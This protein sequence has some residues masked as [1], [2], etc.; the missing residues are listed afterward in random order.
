MLENDFAECSRVTQRLDVPQNPTLSEGLYLHASCLSGVDRLDE[1]RAYFERSLAI[2]SSGYLMEYADTLAAQREYSAARQVL[3][4]NE[5]SGSERIDL[6]LERPSVMYPIDRGEWDTGARI[7]DDLASQTALYADSSYFEALAW[8]TS[9]RLFEQPSVLLGRAIADWIEAERQREV[10]AD[11]RYREQQLFGALAAGYIAMR[12]G[13][14][15]IAA[16]ALALAGPRARTSRYPLHLELLDLM[17]AERERVE[18][19]PEQAIRRLQPRI[20]G[21]E[22][23]QTR[24]ALKR[25][26][27]DAGRWADARA[28]AE[29]LATHRGRAYAERTHRPLLM[30]LNVVDSNLAQLDDAEYSLQ[31]RDPARARQRYEQFL[32]V[33]PQAESIAWLQPRLEKIENALASSSF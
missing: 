33:W 18:G 22:L 1:A 5:E 9:V 28:E 11:T 25:A 4:R 21:T 3:A 27:A 26:Y 23:Y 24:S 32:T 7:A 12:A 8:Q 19:R 14:P 17:E 30:V 2:G 16:P 20:S 10:P 31:L 6:D 29:W 13:A 15:D